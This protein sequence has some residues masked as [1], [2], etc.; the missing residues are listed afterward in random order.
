MDV[1]MKG[2]LAVLASND[3]SIALVKLKDLSMSKIFKQA[4]SF[5]IT[6]VTISPDSTYVASVS[7]ANTIHIIKLPLNYANYTSMKQKNL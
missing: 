5:A 1:D 6:E 7:A 3:N 4:H 2:E